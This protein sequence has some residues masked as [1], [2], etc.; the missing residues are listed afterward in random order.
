MDP[1][2]NT[3]QRLATFILFKKTAFSIKFVKEWLSYSSDKRI[4]SDDE[5]N[6][7]KKMTPLSKRIGMI[8]QYLVYYQKN[9]NLMVL[10]THRNL[11]IQE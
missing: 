7:E 10:G 3:Y 9:I 6:V 5:I 2:Y 8:N 4:I 1:Y 11:A